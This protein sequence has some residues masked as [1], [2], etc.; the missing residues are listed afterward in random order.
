MQRLFNLA[1]LVVIGLSLAAQTIRFGLALSGSSSPFWSG[2]VDTLG[3]AIFPATA[4]AIVKCMLF[5]VRS[6][7]G[8]GGMALAGSYFAIAVW[9]LVLGGIVAHNAVDALAVPE[10]KGP[11]REVAMPPDPDAT[12][13]LREGQAWAAAHRPT[14]RRECAGDPE[15]VRGCTGWIRAER[16]AQARAGSEWAQQNRPVRA[17]QCQGTPDFV[18]G[19]RTW[20]V[21]NAGGAQQGAGPFGTASAAE[22]RT[23]VDANYENLRDLDL[24]DGNEKAVE[25]VRR[26]QWEPDLQACERLPGGR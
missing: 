19:C 22:C 18:L 9:P 21:Q 23:E 25:Q 15:F 11:F 3:A 2:L 16:D 17:S 26:R 5:T 6:I 4:I 7:R 20:Y 10:A 13:S 8:D 24:L 1:F 12:A 14:L